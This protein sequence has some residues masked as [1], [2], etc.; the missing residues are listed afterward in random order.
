LDF[1]GPLPTF[2]SLQALFDTNTFL[3]AG[4]TAYATDVLGS[5]KIA[6]ALGQAGASENPEGRTDLTLTTIE[7]DTG[8]LIPV[9]GPAVNP[10]S[11]EFGGYFNVTY[12]YV[13]GV[14][15][16]IFADS[17]SIYLDLT[18]Y[19]A[20]DIAII[21]LAE[22]NGR[23]VM[24]VWGYGWEGTYAASVFLG[25][26]NNWSLFNGYHMAMIRWVDSNTDGLVQ[27]GEITV[28]A[29]T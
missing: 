5:A 2:G 4:D 12:N 11:T 10:I 22:H 21:Y 26:I 29:Q 27:A 16:E 20:E 9:G 14:R 13:P 18:L 24:M 23:Y 25:D 8:N 28:E 19:P 7:H 3:V 6:F 15:F 1:F 17:Q